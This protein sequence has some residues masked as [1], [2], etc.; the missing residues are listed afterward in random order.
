M[1]AKRER[2]ER[3]VST[4]A[5][6][7]NSVNY[8]YAMSTHQNIFSITSTRYHQTS[9]TMKKKRKAPPEISA[10]SMADIAFLLLIFFLVATQ[11]SQ[12]KGI[13]VILPEYYDGPAGKVI[14][15]DVLNIKINKFDEVM[16]E[17]KPT[18]LPD[19]A[20]LIPEFVL[21]PEK[22][23][24]YPTSPSKAIISLQNDVNTSYDAYVYAYSIIQS[25]YTNMRREL[26][27]SKFGKDLTELTALQVGEIKKALPMK[28]SE[29]DPFEN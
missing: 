19:L 24:D 4:K 21:N 22:R 27:K 18:T 23:S 5:K 29:A 10:G 26:S 6:N 8:Q 17:G 20:T 2:S 3:L 25:S 9:R 15:R 28:V 1:I 13:R 7:T 14:D 12:D 16:V 11:I